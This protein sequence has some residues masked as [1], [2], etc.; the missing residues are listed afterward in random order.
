MDDALF[1]GTA[2]K[3]EAGRET[4]GGVAAAA[5]AGFGR[6]RRAGVPCARSPL[7]SESRSTEM[8]LGARRSSEA[9]STSRGITVGG[10]AEGT[11]LRRFGLDSALGRSERS[12]TR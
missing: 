12:A 2:A 11:T 8:G 3:R 9:T 4:F 7:G 1:G 5:A 10:G 6:L